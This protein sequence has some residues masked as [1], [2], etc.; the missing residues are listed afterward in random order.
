[1]RSV[2][3]LPAYEAQLGDNVDE[4]PICPLHG[5]S[6]SFMQDGGGRLTMVRHVVKE[7]ESTDS[8]YMNHSPCWWVPR[9]TTN[10][11]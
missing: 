1:M 10:L 6:L 9:R 2:K 7:Q 8:L 3:L 5:V 11:P 4:L